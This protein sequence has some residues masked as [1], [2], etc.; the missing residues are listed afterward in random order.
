MLASAYIIC[1]SATPLSTFN[2]IHEKSFNKDFSVRTV[3]RSDFTREINP[4]YR[5]RLEFC[6][7]V[8]SCI[9][10]Y[11]MPFI[12]STFHSPLST[13]HFPLLLSSHGFFFAKR[14]TH[15]FSFLFYNMS[16]A[17]SINFENL[18]SFYFLQEQKQ[19]FKQ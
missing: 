17:L 15:E 8:Y 16:R 1:K 2:L 11:N 19:P 7:K 9:S 13:L 18:N 14:K 10:I 12:N 4:R 6:R 5:S 3:G